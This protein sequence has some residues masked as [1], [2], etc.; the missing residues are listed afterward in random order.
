M[1]TLNICLYM[2][3]LPLKKEV[4]PK[5]LLHNIAVKGH[6]DMGRKGER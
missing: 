5:E 4:I 3:Q 2:K 1:V 6:T